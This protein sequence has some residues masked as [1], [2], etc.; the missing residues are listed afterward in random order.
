MI[1]DIIT[2]EGVSKS[3]GKNPV[4]DDISHKFRKGGSYAFAGHNGCGKSTMLKVIAGLVRIN[5]GRV[6]Y[7]GK[8]GFS[9]VPEKFTGLDVSMEYYLKSVAGMEGIEFGRVEG[10]IRDFFLEDMRHIRMT[11]MSKGSLQKVGVIQALM[12]PKDVIL[13]DE[14]LSGQDADSQE[15]FISK[16]NELR[17]R[18]ITI[19]MSC[20]E[21]KLMDELSDEVYLIEKGS[22]R[23]R[24]EKEKSGFRIYVRRYDGKECW[25]EMILRGHKYMLPVKEE[26]IKETVMK[27]YDEGWELVGIEEY[28]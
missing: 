23:S 26:H 25:P 1:E 13:L 18:G 14:P 4:L 24:E 10:L 20:H 2:L 17:T 27:L 16:V 9:Y 28:I 7:S 6:R 12:A 22:L 3:Y 15:V 11:H 8:V 5:R 21:K 19:F